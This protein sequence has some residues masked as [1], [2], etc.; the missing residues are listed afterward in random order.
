MDIKVLANNIFY[1]VFFF[2]FVNKIKNKKCCN[3]KIKIIFDKRQKIDIK[4]AILEPERLEMWLYLCFQ[5][6]LIFFVKVKF[7][8]C[9]KSF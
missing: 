2:H 1:V 9:F 5:K 8:I 4:L 6:I 3:K 7:F